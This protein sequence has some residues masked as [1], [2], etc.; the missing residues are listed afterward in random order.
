MQIRIDLFGR[1]S[2][3]NNTS[4]LAGFPTRKTAELLLALAVH[5]DQPLSRRDIIALLWPESRGGKANNR[6]SA[7][8]YM[9]RKAIEAAF[10]DESAGLIGAGEGS[11]WL[12]GDYV[13][14]ITEMEA[15]WRAYAAAEPAED[16]ETAASRILSLYTGHLA[17]ELG[18]QWYE[19]LQSLWASRWTEA[20]IWRVGAGYGQL[21]EMLE[22]LSSIQPILPVTRSLVVSFLDDFG[23]ADL[24]AS[25]RGPVRPRPPMAD[26]AVVSYPKFTVEQPDTLIRRPTLTA[27]VVDPE[28]VPLLRQL[29]SESNGVTDWVGSPQVYCARNPLIARR[30]AARIRARHPMTRIYIST[31]VANPDSRDDG[32]L[33]HWLEELLPGETLMNT[34][35]AS[36]I[37]Q[38]D[39]S[40]VMERP[41]GKSGYRLL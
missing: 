17:A 30:F 5:P 24:A 11:I 39:R 33:L 41:S 13:S 36:L 8:L 35:A 29:V 38:H 15:A 32:R 4:T 18:G 2:A 23:R 3:S 27:V 25:W 34:A 19:P 10:G 9:L 21:D 28:A 26:R 7:T 20:A 14:S 40:V 31:E 22:R 16:K 1:V 37:E 12:Q 6:L